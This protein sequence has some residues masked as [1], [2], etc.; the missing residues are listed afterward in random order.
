M[1]ADFETVGCDGEVETGDALLAPVSRSAGTGLAARSTGVS[2]SS[3]VDAGEGDDGEVVS[4]ARSRFVAP[5]AAGAVR[6]DEDWFEGE[7]LSAGVVVSVLEVWA[8][9][10]AGDAG[11][12]GGVK[13]VW[14][15]TRRPFAPGRPKVD[16]D[17]TGGLSGSF[18]YSIVSCEGT[19]LQNTYGIFR[20]LRIVLFNVGRRQVLQAIPIIGRFIQTNCR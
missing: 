9:V 5:T 20:L 3:A 18:S 8:G 14:I 17:G 4:T 2:R 16:V 1:D 10:I 7:V 13:E 11:D 15:S 6:R 19:R 12:A